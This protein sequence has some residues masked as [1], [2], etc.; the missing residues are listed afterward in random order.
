MP[1]LNLYRW[2]GTEEGGREGSDICRSQKAKLSPS[3][4]FQMLLLT[5][6]SFVFVSLSNASQPLCQHTLHCIADI[7]MSIEGCMLRCM[8]SALDC[9]IYYISLSTEET[10]LQAQFLVSEKRAF[11]RCGKIYH[12]LL[13]DNKLSPALVHDSKK[14]A[15][16]QTLL[17]PSFTTW[18]PLQMNWTRN[19]ERRSPQIPWKPRGSLDKKEVWGKKFNKTVGNIC[20]PFLNWEIIWKN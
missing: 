10:K 5:L 6:T 2:W 11:Q 1:D 18:N 19:G 16:W 13:S 3:W 20:W 15:L 12:N 9:G 4:H 7:E 8:H 17:W 14:K